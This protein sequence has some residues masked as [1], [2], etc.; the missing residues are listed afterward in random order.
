M[1]DLKVIAALVAAISVITGEVALGDARDGDEA[2]K[3]FQTDVSIQFGETGA[4]SD[5]FEVPADGTTIVL[6]YV[7]CS[8]SRSPSASTDAAF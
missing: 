5:V 8:M 2:A 3:P 7:S 6:Q 4:R 1:I